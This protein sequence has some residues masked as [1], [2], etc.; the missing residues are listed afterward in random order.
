[1]GKRKKQTNQEIISDGRDIEFSQEFADQDDL[2]A[3]ERSQAADNRAKK[4]K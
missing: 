3:Q 2:E 1:M 4:K